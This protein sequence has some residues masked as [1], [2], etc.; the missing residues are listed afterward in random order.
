MVNTN[1]LIKYGAIGLLGYWGLKKLGKIRLFGNGFGSISG[2]GI[3]GATPIYLPP[4]ISGGLTAEEAQIISS[5]TYADYEAQ[6][7]AISA[8]VSSKISI[9]DTYDSQL[10][11]IEVALQSLEP[12]ILS[13][14]QPIASLEFQI[15]D[16]QQELAVLQQ[17]QQLAYTNYIFYYRKREKGI[18]TPAEKNNTEY[19]QNQYE[20]IT[21]EVDDTK[22]YISNLQSQLQNLLDN[23]NRDIQLKNEYIDNRDEIKRERIIVEKLIADLNVMLSDLNGGVQSNG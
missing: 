1:K 11:E 14:D 12:V 16:K 18:A 13:Y 4:I 23:K 22:K 7:E 9:L 19:W 6:Q 3:S 8:I 21:S 15:E 10:Y 2:G 17:Q 5:Q 20:I